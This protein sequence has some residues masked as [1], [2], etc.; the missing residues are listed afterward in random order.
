MNSPKA[1]KDGILPNVIDLEGIKSE[2]NLYVQSFAKNINFP[3]SKDEI[4]PTSKDALI[5]LKNAFN[6]FGIDYQQFNATNCQG[7]TTMIGRLP[8]NEKNQNFSLI[9]FKVEAFF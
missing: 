4:P 3:S 9:N 1:I 5:L 2:K 7:I 8:L 6:F